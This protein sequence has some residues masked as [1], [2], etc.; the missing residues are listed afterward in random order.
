[1]FAHRDRV[2]ASRSGFDHAAFV[3]A[4]FPIAIL[5]GDIDFHPSQPIFEPREA[6]ASRTFQVKTKCLT[7]FDIVGCVDLDVQVGLMMPCGCQ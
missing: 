1:M 3:L 2:K 4:S 7:S 5:V 6:F